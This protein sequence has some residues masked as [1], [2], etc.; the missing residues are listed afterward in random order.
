MQIEVRA[1]VSVIRIS[2]PRASDALLS[3]APGRH[4]A[5]PAPRTAA[6]RKLWAPS[7]RLESE[8]ESVPRELIDEA[9][10]L[11]FPG[12]RSFTGEDTV[13]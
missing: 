2:G 6:L 12:P 3:L 9:L 7:R 10:V 8:G 4:G 11:W 1:G 13:S 5:L